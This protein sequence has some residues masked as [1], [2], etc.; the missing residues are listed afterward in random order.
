MQVTILPT[1]RCNVKCL[2]CHCWKVEEDFISVDHILN[3]IEDLITWQSGNFVLHIGGGEPLI[4]KGIEDIIKKCSENNIICKVTTNGYGLTDKMCDRL[5]HA[6]LS[7]LTVSLDSHQPDVH[8][9]F[10]GR[11]GTFERAVRGIEYLSKHSNMTLG[12]SSILMK[13]NIEGIDQFLDF[14][15]DLDT[16]RI[17]FQPIRD[18][19]NPIDRWQ[20]YSYWIADE[21]LLDR[22]I[23]TLIA[24]RKAHDKILNPISDFKVMQEYFK[25]PYSIVNNQE[26]YIGYERL[27]VDDKGQITLCDAYSSIGNIKDR[28][29]AS[30]WKSATANGERIRMKSCTLPCTSNCKKDLNLSE[31]VMKFTQL[32]RAGLFERS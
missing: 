5:I 21:D 30:Q 23:D 27:F 3:F 4:F 18:Y 26:C 22:G 16:N 2:M 1:Q 15:L 32:Y 20:T 11:A 9:N 6:G 13:D 17:L 8:N 7:Y 12:T 19:Y 10:R 24:Y 29:I 14:L 31:K 28:Q 25:D